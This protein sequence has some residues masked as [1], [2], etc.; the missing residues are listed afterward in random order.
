M[1]SFVLI[2]GATGGLGKAFA[3]EC[4]ARGWD[5]FLTDLSES[6][7]ALLAGGLSRLYNVEIKYRPCNLADPAAREEFLKSLETAGL[8][9][10]FLINNAGLDFEG[11]FTERTPEELAAVIRLNIEA[12]VAITRWVLKLRD[13]ARTFRILNVSSL[14]GFYPMPIKAVYAASKRFLLQFSLA[15]HCELRDEDVTVMALCPAG[16]PSNPQVI[17]SINAQGFMGRITAKNVGFVAAKAID[18]ALAGRT[19]Y[20]PGLL[21][22]FLSRLGNLVPPS[23]SAALINRRWREAGKRCTD[24]N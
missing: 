24:G 6:R 12:T 19:V 10:H 9:F 21:N 11:P 18:R 14:A 8:Q 13:P 20:I 17:T 16:M 1:R 7:L 2:T 15:L 4:A 3:A 22:L 23:V 5:L